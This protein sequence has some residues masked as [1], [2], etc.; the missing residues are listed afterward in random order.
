MISTKHS[1]RDGVVVRASASRVDL[2]FIPKSNHTKRLLEKMVFTASL[3]G[4]QHK[5]G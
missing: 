2:E 4:A 5:K 1:I 3:L